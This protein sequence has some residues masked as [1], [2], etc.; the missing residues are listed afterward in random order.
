[1]PDWTVEMTAAQMKITL[2]QVSHAGIGWSGA[3][4]Q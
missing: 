4:F 3:E 1:M 2:N